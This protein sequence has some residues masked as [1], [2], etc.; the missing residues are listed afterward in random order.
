MDDEYVSIETLT[1]RNLPEEDFALPD[2]SG[3]VRLRALSRAEALRVGK[4]GGNDGALGERLTLM[5]G[6]VRPV[7]SEEKAK[8]WQAAERA[9]ANIAAVCDRIKELSGVNPEA[10]KRHYKSDAGRSEPGVRP[11]PS[12][13]T[14]ADGG[15]AAGVDQ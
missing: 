12:G 5:T 2:G 15:G 9:G 4:L 11:L 8:A 1:T 3:K 13:E 10:E 14:G 7:L 6:V